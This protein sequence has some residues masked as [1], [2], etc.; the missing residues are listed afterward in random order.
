MYTLL[1]LRFD[2]RE[3]IA[4]LSGSPTIAIMIWGTSDVIQVNATLCKAI[5]ALVGGDVVMDLERVLT[6]SVW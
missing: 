5:T 3:R 4:I 1:P 6:Q 2:R